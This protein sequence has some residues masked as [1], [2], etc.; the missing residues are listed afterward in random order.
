MVARAALRFRISIWFA[1][2]LTLTGTVIGVLMGAIQGYF[3]G[4]IDLGMQ[5]VIEIWGA[6]PSCTC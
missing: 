6:V 5:R 1:M 3:G 4:R 2:A